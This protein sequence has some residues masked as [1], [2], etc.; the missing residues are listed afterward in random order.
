[1]S[2]SLAGKLSSLTPYDP[3]EGN[4]EVRLD[5]N[6]SY[7]N[8]NEEYPEIFSK[9]LSEIKFN[10]YPDPY[11]DSVSKAFAEYY[12]IKP[13]YVTAGNGSDE[14]ISII[15]GC[16]LEKG[17]KVVTLTPD[18]SMYAFYPGLYELEVVSFKKENDLSADVDKLIEC[19]NSVN[20]KMLIFSNPCNPTS[21]GITRSD[22]I[23]ILDNVKCLVVLDE[24]YMD[25]WTESLLDKTGEYDNLII[26][27]T[28]SKSIGMAGIR[29]GF[30]VAGEK[31][32][33]ALKMV[34][35]PYNTD[36]V[37]QKLAET[38]F[39]MKDIL[40]EKNREIVSQNA[41]LLSEIKK[42]HEKYPDIL[43]KAYES[44]TN[45]V[46][47]KTKFSEQIFSALKDKSIIIRKFNGFIR[48]TAGSINENSALI[49]GL[50]EALADIK[51]GINENG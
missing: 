28:C 37:S 9:A 15:T 11:A 46:F 24:A 12:D 1:M 18:F 16:F 19:C 42:L 27:K 21:L 51:E 33:Q 17:D 49:S 47:V 44:V 14:L 35:S 50:S 29:L 26:L 2:Y 45:F 13:E 8:I 39:K 31:L 25:F 43:E 6:E 5:A 3:I 34:K 41:F 23:K 32:T 40:K 48:I 10:R 7:Y 22:V 36:S 30:A 4:F 20:A 38:V